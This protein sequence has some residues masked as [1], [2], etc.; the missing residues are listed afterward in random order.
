MLHRPH[1]RRGDTRRANP[2][3]CGPGGGAAIGFGC[4]LPPQGPRRKA[5]TCRT[6][7]LGSAPIL[8]A[9]R[10]AVLRQ[11]DVSD[12]NSAAGQTLSS[13]EV[14]ALDTAVASLLGPPV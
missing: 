12:A 1:S 5:A 13:G 7:G 6:D 9:S 2:T 4:G 14:R 11:S 10:V 8:S 3:I